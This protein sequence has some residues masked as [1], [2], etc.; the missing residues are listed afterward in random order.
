MCGTVR[1]GLDAKDACVD[2][3]FKVFGLERLRV[4]DLSVCPLI[5]K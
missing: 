3:S 1:M 5:P 2:S 4:V